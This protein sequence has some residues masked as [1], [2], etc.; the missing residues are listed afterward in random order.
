M[1]KCNYTAILQNH[2][3]GHKAPFT[4]VDN[5]QISQAFYLISEIIYPR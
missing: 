4:K 1:L 5:K 3:S 2:T